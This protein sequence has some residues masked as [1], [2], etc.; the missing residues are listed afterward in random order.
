LSCL[1]KLTIDFGDFLDPALAFSVF[2]SQELRQWPMELIGDV[3]YLLVQTVEG[4]AYDSP[5]R[6]A[7]STSKFAWHSGQVTGMVVCPSSLMRR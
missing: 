4:V 7:K 2:Q 6:S 3:G 5:P 1:S